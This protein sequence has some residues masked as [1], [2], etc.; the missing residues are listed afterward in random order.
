MACEL[1]LIL[2]SLLKTGQA[3]AVHDAYIFTDILNSQSQH[4][5][6]VEIDCSAAV[7]GAVRNKFFHPI[8][9]VSDIHCL[10]VF[11]L[12]IAPATVSD[13]AC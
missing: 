1:I 5:C 4:V 7:L 2:I 12:S 10:Q 11:C 9:N 13:L 3:S 8:K 6:F